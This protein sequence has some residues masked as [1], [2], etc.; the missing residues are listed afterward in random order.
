M[1][2]SI[3]AYN[4]VNDRVA[5]GQKPF[6]DGYDWLRSQGFRTVL[7]IR[8]AGGDDSDERRQAEQRG[9]VFRDLEFSPATLNERTVGDFARTVSDTTAQPLFVYDADGTLAGPLWFVYFRTVERQS[10]DVAR[11]RAERLGLR[12]DGGDE[13]TALW[14]AVQK[15]LADHPAS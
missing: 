2:S 13:Q 5:A 6:P 9:L 15:Y 1:P 3:P 10:S 7:F 12:T 4:W 11:S 8:P 14:L